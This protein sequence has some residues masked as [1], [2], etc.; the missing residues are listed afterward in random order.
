MLSFQPQ[1]EEA[2]KD[3]LGKFLPLTFTSPEV[4]Y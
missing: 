3:P 4:T 1:F 2:A